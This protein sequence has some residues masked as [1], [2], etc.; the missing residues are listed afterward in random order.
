MLVK[1]MGCITILKAKKNIYV[2]LM[3]SGLN[4]N[5]FYVRVEGSL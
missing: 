5:E 4:A 2:I 1:I 3:V